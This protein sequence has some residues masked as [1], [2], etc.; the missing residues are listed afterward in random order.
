MKAIRQSVR[1]W[2]AATES[3]QSPL[4]D[5]Q[6]GESLRSSPQS[7][8]LARFSG[9]P[10]KPARCARFKGKMNRRRGETFGRLGSKSGSYSRH[11]NRRAATNPQFPNLTVRSKPTATVRG[12]SATTKL[13]TLPCEHSPPA[14]W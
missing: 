8:T 14:A 10:G 11:F 6:N 5:S 13:L 1:F 7:K 12:R 4:W 2:S 9:M 3:A